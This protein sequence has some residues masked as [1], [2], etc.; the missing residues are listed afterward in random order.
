MKSD[1]SETIELLR[2]HSELYPLMEPRDAVKL[3]YQ[4]E[5][6]C[7]HMVPD[8]DRARA[9]L[10]AE[11]E[12][13]ERDALHR[14]LDELGGGFVRVHLQPIPDLAR[15]DALAEAFILSAVPCGSHEGFMLRLE[16][17]R[18]AAGQ[19]I[20][21]FSP[22]ALEAFLKD[23]LPHGCPAVHHSE[24]F[25]REYRPSYRVIKKALFPK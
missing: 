6:G 10:K 21:P 4:S 23:Y 1:Y 8:P 16:A 3:L 14:P 13:T 19:G 12:N 24:A 9:F 25:R 11:W 17:L 15:L 2:L 7:G 20:T 22:E 18:S 5:F